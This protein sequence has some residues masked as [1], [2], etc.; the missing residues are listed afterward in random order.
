MARRPW[1]QLTDKIQDAQFIWT[2]I[3]VSSIFSGQ[4]KKD[5]SQICYSDQIKTTSKSKKEEIYKR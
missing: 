3:K 1:F 2:Q 5:A 4:T